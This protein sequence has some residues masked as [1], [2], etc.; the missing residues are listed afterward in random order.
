MLTVT[1]SNAKLVYKGI[2]HSHSQGCS[3]SDDEVSKSAPK[4]AEPARP[5]THPM[6]LTTCAAGREPGAAVT[7]AARRGAAVY[8]QSS[9][10]ISK[11]R[12]PCTC[13]CTLSGKDCKICPMGLQAQAE[14]PTSLFQLLWVQ[15]CLQTSPSRKPGCSVWATSGLSFPHRPMRRSQHRNAT[16]PEMLRPTFC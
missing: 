14:M 5:C 4:P 7:K 13:T 12:G 2:S 15:H 8:S 9:W 11:L 3:S 1:A 16:R 10:V 6:Q